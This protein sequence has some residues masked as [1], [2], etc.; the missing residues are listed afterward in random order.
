MGKTLDLSEFE[1]LTQRKTRKVCRVALAKQNL[2][3]D[4]QEKLEA[5]IVAT[6]PAGDGRVSVG[7]V[8]TWLEQHGET[9]VTQNTVVHHRRRA[10]SCD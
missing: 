5:A 9:A 4:E 10:C 7:A 6:D 1:A 3:A 8:L 2:S